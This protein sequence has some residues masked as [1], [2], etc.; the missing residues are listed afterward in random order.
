MAP[1]LRTEKKLTDI[2]TV[3]HCLSGTDE[4]EERKKIGAKEGKE[5][6]KFLGGSG[7]GGVRP[8]LRRTHENLEHPTDTPPHLTQHNTTQHRSGCNTC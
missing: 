3:A 5:R 2:P 8:N 7:G 1:R 4:E 6:V